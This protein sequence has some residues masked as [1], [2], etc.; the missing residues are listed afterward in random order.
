MAGSA[1]HN[2]LHKDWNQER[3]MRESYS[4]LDLIHMQ[5]IAVQHDCTVFNLM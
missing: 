5:Y 3:K 2:F 1:G 4:S